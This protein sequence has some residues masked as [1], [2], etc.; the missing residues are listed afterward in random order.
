VNLT[1]AHQ[2]M[3][4][5]VRDETRPGRIELELDGTIAHLRIDNPGAR[6]ALT[7]A[8]MRDLIAAVQRLAEFDEGSLLV[9]SSTDPTAFCAGGHL[10]DVERSLAEPGTAEQM[11]RAMTTA[12]DALAD[13]PM[14]SVAALNGLAIGGGAELAVSCDWRVAAP[15]A[16][17]HFIHS[18]LGITPGWGG[19]ARLVRIVGQSRAL[20]IL[21]SARWISSGEAQW[22]GLVDK[23]CEG[24]AV[25]E[26]VRWCRTVLSRS[27]A[28]VRAVKKQIVAARHGDRE[29]ASTAFAEVW[30]GEA[31]R[32]ALE[33]LERHRR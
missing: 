24:S 15:E 25:D 8:M 13:L 20:R 18:R 26:A 22:L 31:H 4:A 6:G 17:I 7:V 21:T 10:A 33:R 32:R 1:E 19:T 29:A 14:P 11:S 16:R 5:L 2:T 3:A 30:G 23:R 28:A 27:P 12:L 9:V